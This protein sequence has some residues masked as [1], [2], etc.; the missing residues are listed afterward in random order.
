MTLTIPSWIFAALAA[1]PHGIAAAFLVLLSALGLI[2]IPV[3]AVR[4]QR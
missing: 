2:R 4:R 1:L 3:L